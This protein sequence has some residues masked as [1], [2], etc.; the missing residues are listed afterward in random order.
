M[1]GD[2]E[3]LV[4]HFIDLLMGLFRG[5]VFH[6]GGAPE[7]SSFRAALKGTNL[8]GQT[9]ICGFLRVPALSGL[10]PVAANR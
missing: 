4:V 7:N 2:C 5:A 3:T 10:P 1:L 9:P 6:H 8:R